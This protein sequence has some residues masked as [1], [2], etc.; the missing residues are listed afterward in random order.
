MEVKIAVRNGELS[1]SIQDKIRQKLSKLPRFFDRITGIQVIADMKHDEPK[2]EAI[3]S[4]EQ[5]ADFFASDSGSN[6][7]VAVDRVCSKI[8]QQVRKHKEK[9]TEHRDRESISDPIV[10]PE[11]TEPATE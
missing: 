2:V 6:V 5:V 4:A 10:E 11:P 3:V 1:D 7:L 8:E 9:L